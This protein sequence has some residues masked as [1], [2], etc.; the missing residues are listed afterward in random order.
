VARK[1][2]IGRGECGKIALNELD[3]TFLFSLEDAQDCPYDIYLKK[4][5]R[6]P[7]CSTAVIIQ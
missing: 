7:I 5:Y 3:S 2:V 1:K 6:F 4:G